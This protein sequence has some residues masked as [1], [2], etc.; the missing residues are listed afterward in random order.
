MQGSS[1]LFGI[2]TDMQFGKLK[3]Q[4]V[5]SQ[6]KS[7]NKSVSSSGGKQLTPFEFDAAD[8]EENRHFFLSHSFRS[9]YDDAMK[10]LPNLTTGITINRVEIWVT[11][12]NGCNY[13][14]PQHC[15]IERFGRK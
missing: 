13:Q 3:L 12:K 5:L 8:Y 15:C 11:N 9:R 14:Y 10:T 6:K 4:T 1:S 7:S 2:R